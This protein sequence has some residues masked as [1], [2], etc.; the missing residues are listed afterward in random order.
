VRSHQGPL[1][2]TTKGNYHDY[3]HHLLLGWNAGKRDHL[4]GEL[5]PAMFLF[6]FTFC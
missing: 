1:S 5:E 3:L 6:R 4:H 2:V